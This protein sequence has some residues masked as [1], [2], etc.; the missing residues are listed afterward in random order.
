MAGIGPYY[1]G[2]HVHHTKEIPRKG[3]LILVGPARL[4]SAAKRL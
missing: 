2:I 3:F 4:D 1:F